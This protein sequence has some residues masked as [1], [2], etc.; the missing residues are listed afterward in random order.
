MVEVL[1][2][3]IKTSAFGNYVADIHPFIHPYNKFQGMYTILWTPSSNMT[4][5]KTKAQHRHICKLNRVQKWH[6]REV[7]ADLGAEESRESQLT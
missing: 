1:N 2:G 3:P 5:M 4:Q 7:R 6:G